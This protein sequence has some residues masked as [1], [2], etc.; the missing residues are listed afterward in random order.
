[1]PALILLLPACPTAPGLASWLHDGRER[2][3]RRGDHLNPTANLSL[4]PPWSCSDALAWS[5][6]SLSALE[7]AVLPP[8]GP[9]R[10]CV[11]AER[12]A[13]SGDREAALLSRSPRSKPRPG[14]NVQRCT[15][16]GVDRVQVCRTVR[17]SSSGNACADQSVSAITFSR[18]DALRLSRELLQL[19][20]AL[21]AKISPTYM[22]ALNKAKCP[23]VLGVPVR[24]K[25]APELR[26]AE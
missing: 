2:C 24:K 17:R 8:S 10:G 6:A 4:R 3:C 23:L 21:D 5:L 13:L 25:A 15:K 26:T 14:S 11:R 22:L 18:P 19:Q 1:M 16:C 7:S 9:G 20:R 12:G